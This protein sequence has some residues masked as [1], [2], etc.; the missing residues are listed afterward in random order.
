MK[1]RRGLNINIHLTNRWLYTFIVIG[2]LIIANTFFVSAFLSVSHLG[3]NIIVK[4][5]SN[6]VNLDSSTSNFGVGH[7]YSSTPDLTMG[8]H[9]ASQVWVSVK[10]GEMTLL[11]ALQSTNHLCPLANP[12]LTYSSTSIP[13]P[14][15]LATEIDLSSGKTFQKAI[16]DGNFCPV[17]GRWSDWSSWSDPAGFSDGAGGT[18]SKSCATGTQTRT[19]TCTNPAPSNGGAPC[20][21]SASEIQNCN[22]QCCPV[23][24]GW[25]EFGSCIANVGLCGTGTQTRTCIGASC[26]GT[27]S[28]S[29]TQTCTVECNSPAVCYQNMCCLKSSCPANS[30]G[31]NY[32]DGCGGT[33]NCANCA[34]DETCSLDFGTWACKK[35]ASCK[36]SG[37]AD[38]A[39]VCS[40]TK[41]YDNCG[42]YCWDGTKPTSNAHWGTC[43]A[44]A[45]GTSGKKTCFD[46]VCGGETPCHVPT[47][48][49]GSQ[50]DCSAPA[51][52]CTP[53]CSCSAS[54]CTGSTCS[55]GCPGGD[56]ACSGSKCCQTC[57]GFCSDYICRGSGTCCS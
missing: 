31:P 29:P 9:N 53:S 25:S 14:S 15:H 11:Q 35:I 27:C 44:T 1:K 16:N 5:D 7:T 4:V 3:S 28:G 41:I 26:G 10:D 37:C 55:N 12:T 57:N 54:T 36:S 24:G 22:T 43:S 23:N 49:V 46:A 33:L 47:G 51:C 56:S 52:P 42:T 34:S 30:C 18:C 50:I 19:R 21:G 6:N 20:S 39:A 17:N 2:I 13:N 8:Q 32:D 40:G 45:C 48:S 38:P